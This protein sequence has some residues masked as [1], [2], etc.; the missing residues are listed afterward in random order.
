MG[1]ISSFDEAFFLFTLFPWTLLIYI[2][3][4]LKGF[5]FS[6][7]DELTKLAGRLYYVGKGSFNATLIAIFNMIVGALIVTDTALSNFDQQFGFFASLLVFLFMPIPGFLL[8]NFRREEHE[9]FYDLIYQKITQAGEAPDFIMLTSELIRNSERYT[10]EYSKQ[11]EKIQK[12][13][14][15]FLELN[16][17]TIS[18]YFNPNMPFRLN[19]INLA[20]FLTKKLT[21]LEA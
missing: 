6:E 7:D 10:Q 9:R 1:I 3:F 13:V 11:L 19:S 16:Y 2:I 4:G 5:T 20:F 12:T 14:F 18:S 17:E 8:V 15:Q 21:N